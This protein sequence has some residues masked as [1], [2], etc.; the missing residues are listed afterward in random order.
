GEILIEGQ[1]IS[2]VG[3]EK[4][5]RNKVGIIFQSYNLIRYMTALENVL[6][7]MSITENTLPK[8]HKE[9]AYNL[10]D[11]LG[12]TKDK[13]DRSVTKLSGGEQ[14]RVAIARALATNVD[15]ILADEPTGNLNEEME[16]EL[17]D[18]F[19]KLASEHNK[20][21]IV[22]THSTVIANQSD[23]SYRLYKGKLSLE[24]E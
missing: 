20:C 9:I 12:I 16:T 21:V 18:I 17:I 15:L 10:L 8:N 19:K 1:T 13:A 23:V 4:Y 14:Q 11:Y 6:V 24:R 7:A 5:R 3:L 2:S 22:V